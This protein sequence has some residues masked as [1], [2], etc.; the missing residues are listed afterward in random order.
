M[1]KSR[2]TKGVGVSRV[3][4]IDRAYGELSGGGYGSRVY[5]VLPPYDWEV[6]GD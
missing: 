5:V 1:R 6:Q 2:Q 4:G 3:P